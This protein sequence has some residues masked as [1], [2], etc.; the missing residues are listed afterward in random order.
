MQP[1]F[2]DEFSDE[3]ENLEVN[4]FE[5]YDEIK[6]A[7]ISG[8]L[9]IAA[10]N[11]ISAIKAA[12]KGEDIK[13][14]A[15][16]SN[17]GSALVVKKDS[18]IENIE[19]LKG[20]TIG[21]FPESI[22]YVKL[23]NELKEKGIDIKKD[24]KFKEMDLESMTK[25]LS[26]GNIDAFCG[27]EPYV[28]IALEDGFGKVID[29]K[30]DEIVSL[31]TAIIA[32]EENIKDNPEK[33]RELMDKHVKSTNHL[34]MSKEDRINKAAEFGIDKKYLEKS[35]DNI[36]LSTDISPE[37]IEEVKKL[38]EEM[39]EIGMIDNIP[40]IENMFDLSMLENSMMKR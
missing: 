34:M 16:M 38:A 3:S 22:E 30:S 39:K 28:S 6:D 5:G 29:Y 40:N 37:M 8:K 18:G 24:V 13:V 4:T 35:I 32:T 1:F 11:W 21:Y 9:D 20:K 36:E 7:V 33:M 15:G 27:E 14:I 2:Y 12:E 17:G 26:G 31:N 23:A 19:D 10:T 25:G